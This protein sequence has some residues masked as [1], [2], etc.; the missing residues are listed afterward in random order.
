M[1]ETTFQSSG[2]QPVL[3]ISQVSITIFTSLLR[4]ALTNSWQLSGHR[5][6]V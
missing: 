6:Q 3:I 2:N 4:M 1:L 5:L